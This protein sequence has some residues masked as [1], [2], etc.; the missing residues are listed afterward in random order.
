MVTSFP[1]IMVE[2]SLKEHVGVSEVLGTEL[3]VSAQGYCT[4]L[5]RSL[6]MGCDKVD[7]VKKMLGEEQP[8]VGLGSNAAADFPFLM[9]C[10]EAYIVAEDG[11]ADV[12][13]REKYWK[14]LVFHDGR[15]KVRPTPWVVLTL[16]LWAPFGF[17]LSVARIAAAV[18]L[19]MHLAYFCVALLGVSFRITGAP[20]LP[21]AEDK[22]MRGLLFVCNHR[23]LLDPTFLCGGL[24]RRV[25]AL[26]YSLSR[27]SEL[28]SP[29]P[30]TQLTRDRKQDARL[31]GHL[32]ET[33]GD[34]VVCP[35]G[36]TCREPYLL[37]FSSL[38][39]E[40]TEH[41][42]PVALRVKTTMF[43]GSSARGYKALDAFFFLMNPRPRYEVIFLERLGNEHTMAS[44]KSSVEVAKTVQKQIAEALGYEC[45][46]WTRKDKYTLLAGHDG[47]VKE[48][49]GMVSLAAAIV[50]ET[51]LLGCNG[52]KHAA[53][54]DD[55]SF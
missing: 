43:W 16:F 54:D 15:L 39:A 2:Y 49:W 30:T 1:R 31:I 12:V 17:L 55:K 23:T 4:G 19:P 7:A 45:T 53:D 47:T 22:Q 37:R 46:E 44:G 33:E 38:F 21:T 28:I 11:A 29:I 25:R 10:K 48:K 9:I 26:T 14:P 8:D 24:R 18:C 35:E 34:L 40:L 3:Q 5:V 52:I 51:V 42:A 32:L 27:I 36:T 20:P 6:M 41:I 13:P 50:P